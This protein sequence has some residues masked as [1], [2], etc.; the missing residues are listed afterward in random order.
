MQQLIAVYII[1]RIISSLYFNYEYRAETRL[2]F[3]TYKDI[4]KNL[5][6]N[7]F[8]LSLRYNKTTAIL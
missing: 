1:R 5:L 3:N 4:A 7:R 8:I 2:I 6:S